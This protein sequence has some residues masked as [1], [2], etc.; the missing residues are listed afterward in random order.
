MAF[1]EPK[2]IIIY[3]PIIKQGS[4][5]KCAVKWKIIHEGF[6]AETL[7]IKQEDF[8]QKEKGPSRLSWVV[9]T[10]IQGGQNSHFYPVPE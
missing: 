1:A 2:A 10:Q 8:N 4:P 3:P 9:K 5:Q 7:T 6:V